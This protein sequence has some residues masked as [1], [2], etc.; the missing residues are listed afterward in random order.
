MIEE[1]EHGPFV[2]VGFDRAEDVRDALTAAGIPFREDG[3]A[4]CSGPV[5]AVFR[6]ERDLVQEEVTAVLAKAIG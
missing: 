1:D 5:Y 6:F 2:A 3:P 4:G